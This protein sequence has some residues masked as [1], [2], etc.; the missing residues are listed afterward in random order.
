MFHR[1]GLTLTLFVGSGLTGIVAQGPGRQKWDQSQATQIV[2]RV[3]E[4]EKKGELPWDAIAWK[5]DA[6]EAVA[7]AQQENKSILLFVYLKK[8]TGPAQAPC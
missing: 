7:A 2:Q 6:G 3:L 5:T 1:I 4:L 8:H